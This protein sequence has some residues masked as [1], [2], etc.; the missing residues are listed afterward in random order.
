MKRLALIIGCILIV[1]VV[2][3]ADNYVYEATTNHVETSSY[4]TADTNL[5]PAIT[6]QSAGGE[7]Q[8][9]YRYRIYVTEAQYT[10]G[11]ATVPQAAK[12]AALAACFAELD[13]YTKFDGDLRASIDALY[14][15]INVLRTD[16]KLGLP[17]LTDAEKKQKIKDKD[18][19]KKKK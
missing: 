10:N 16:P 2:Q 8:P 7:D 4:T 13:D 3:A 15:E 12:E 19:K 14:D 17:A 6:I 9:E 18:P 5:A 11:W 1:T